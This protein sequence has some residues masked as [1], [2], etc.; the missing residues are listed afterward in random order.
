MSERMDAVWL[1]DRL[2]IVLITALGATLGLAPILLVLRM[3]PGLPLR[4]ALWFYLLVALESATTTRW[5][6]YPQQ[7]SA[8]TLSF[9]LGEILTWVVLLR[10][11]TWTFIT[12]WP[13]AADISRWL[14]DPAAF[15]DPPFFLLTL[16]LLLVWDQTAQLTTLF[17]R[18]ALQPDELAAAERARQD[19]WAERSPAYESRKALVDRITGRWLAGAFLLVIVAALSQFTV[20]PEKSLRLGLRSTGL[21]AEFGLL[22]VFY[23]LGGLYL[24]SE[25]YRGALRVQWHYEGTEWREDFRSRWRAIALGLL[26]LTAFIASLIPVGSTAPLAPLAEGFLTLLAEL[27]YALMMLFLFLLSLLL[28]LFRF[29]EVPRG[30]GTPAEESLRRGQEATHSLLPPWLGGALL[31][32]GLLLLVLGLGY[33]FWRQRGFA[34]TWA[35]VRQWL[36]SLLRWGR[37]QHTR[38]RRLMKQGVPRS[39]LPRE[40]VKRVRLPRS[41]VDFTRWRRLT[42]DQRVRYYYIRALK[43]AQRAGLPRHPS[44]TPLEYERLLETRVPEAD[45]DAQ[46]LTHAFIRARYARAPIV[47]EDVHWV[48]RAWEHFKRVLHP[49]PPQERP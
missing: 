39:T 27:G 2:H 47:Q 36:M 49:R 5:L 42:P 21:P 24:R 12:G 23:L 19:R 34:L 13:T 28:S 38:M 7:R 30:E 16:L 32:T 46:I 17:G 3:A 26:L 10:L 37:R 18:L 20:T 41:P 9:R 25:A 48:R 35:D 33:V 44:E 1:E 8:R 11:L 6:G 31:W 15:F 29:E 45:E 43:R 22:L 4:W 40:W 14:V